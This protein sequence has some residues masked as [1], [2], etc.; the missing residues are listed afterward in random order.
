MYIRI[1][2]FRLAGQ[3]RQGK[4]SLINNNWGGIIYLS[5][6]PRENNI[7]NLLLQTIENI[8]A[9]AIHAIPAPEKVYTRWKTMR[10]SMIWNPSTR[11][12][13][14]VSRWFAFIWEQQILD[15]LSPR[16]FLMRRSLEENQRLWS[17]SPSTKERSGRIVEAILVN[18]ACT[19]T[20]R[21]CVSVAH[22]GTQRSR[23]TNLDTSLP[24]ESAFGTFLFYHLIAPFCPA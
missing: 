20:I 7:W 21:I 9:N 12:I 11:R 6:I 24:P 17:R 2:E 18:R 16:W 19:S 4:L 23:S 10:R 22:I 5:A 1:S 3:I 8:F 13:G 15:A 14:A